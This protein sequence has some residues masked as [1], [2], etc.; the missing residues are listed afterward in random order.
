MN[1]DNTMRARL[2]ARLHQCVVLCKIGLVQGTAEDIVDEVLP[3][4]GEAEDVE[5]VGFGKVRHL[6]GAVAAAVLG[7]GRVDRG[8]EAGALGGK[9]RLGWQRSMTWDG[10]KGAC[11]SVPQ[12]KSNPAI[13]TPANL[14]PAATVR[15]A[16][17][18]TIEPARSFEREYIVEK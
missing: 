13:L 18:A 14:T 9:K 3:G 6:A 8:E 15:A 17:K 4:D 16:L 1:I 10:G 7:E 2:Q 12:P 5:S 11:T